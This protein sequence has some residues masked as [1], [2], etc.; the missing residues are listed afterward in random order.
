MKNVQHNI[1]PI[2]QGLKSTKNVKKYT[3]KIWQFIE[4]IR[5]C[6][7]NIFLMLVKQVLNIR[8]CIITE[9]YILYEKCT[10]NII[11]YY[12]KNWKTPKS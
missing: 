11:I 2:L 6:L 12:L 3:Y 10:K 7:V 9:Q 8:I 5:N 1:L 4:M